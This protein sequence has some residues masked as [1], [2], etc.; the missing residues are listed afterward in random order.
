MR[1]NRQLLTYLIDVT[2]LLGRQELSFRGH[3]ESTNSLNRGNFKEIFECM[4]KRNAE[5]S[6]H[7]DKLKHIF[8]GQ[9]K[10]IQNEL[11]SCCEDYLNS[12]IKQEISN[13]NFFAVIADDTTDITEKS[14]CSIT[15]RLVNNIGELK[16]RFLGFF[17]VSADRTASALFE[18]LTDV[19]QPFDFKSK[20]VAQCYDGAS[21]MAG[22][23]NGLQSKIKSVAPSALFIHC[24]AHRLNLVLQQAA[25]SISK[26][27]IFFATILSIPA[28][29]NH[30]PKRTFILNKILNKSIPQANETRW[31]TRSR[32]VNLVN[33][34]WDAHK[35]VFETIINDK[36]SGTESITKAHGFLKNLADFDFAIFT[37]I[38]YN[39]IFIITDPLFKILQKKFLDV[40]YCFCQI[41]TAISRISALRTESTFAGVF[42]CAKRRTGTPTQRG[43]NNNDEIELKTRYRAAFYEILDC[44]IVQLNVRFTDLNKLEFL[45]LVDSSK[46]LEYCKEFPLQALNMLVKT[47]PNIFQ[48]ERLLNELSNIYQDDQFHNINIQHSLDIINKDLQDVFPEVKKLLS[49]VLTIPATS[50]VAERSFSCLKRIKTYLRSTMTQDRLSGLAVMSIEKCLLNEL[51]KKPDFYEAIINKYATLKDRRIDLIYKK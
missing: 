45:S 51:S 2:L 49:L 33:E 1:K 3:D 18:V 48:K 8:T 41:E 50:V 36:T 47:Y 27:R 4:I 14:Q 34:E 20:L 15:I 29:F 17:D 7:A 32:I 24:A 5:L 22:E 37:L 39:Q 6:E 28:F 25:N 9:S 44:I 35:T 38:Y 10:T 13:S 42:E 43:R 26:A 19:L 46:Y 21:V 11:I 16:E 40:K 30:S 23:L 12:F 31:C